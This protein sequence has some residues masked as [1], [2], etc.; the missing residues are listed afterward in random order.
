M[1]QR[2]LLRLIVT[3]TDGAGG[4]VILIDQGL[5]KVLRPD[6]AVVLLGNELLRGGGGVPE[7]LGSR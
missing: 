1:V 7:A 5:R 6:A 4:N 2:Q 3:F